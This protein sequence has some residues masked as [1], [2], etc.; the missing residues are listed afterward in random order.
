MCA[1]AEPHHRYLFTVNRKLLGER[2]VLRAAHTTTRFFPAHGLGVHNGIK[3]PASSLLPP[4]FF[5]L[6]CGFSLMGSVFHN[7][8]TPMRQELPGGNTQEKEYIPVSG[9]K[10]H[11]RICG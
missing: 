6:K 10:G 7:P 3:Y 9:L 5:Q 1:R 2:C 4:C 8:K 11:L